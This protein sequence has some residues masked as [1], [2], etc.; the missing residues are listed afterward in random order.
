M[1]KFPSLA[2]EISQMLDYD[3]EL[4]KKSEDRLG[5]GSLSGSRLTRGQKKNFGSIRNLVLDYHNGIERFINYTLID[6]LGHRD[7]PDK[8]A[9]AVLSRL[10]FDEKVQIIR[11]FK[12]VNFSKVEFEK[13]GAINSIRN[14]FAHGYPLNNKKFLYKKKD[15]KHIVFNKDTM[16]E[17]EADVVSILDKLLSVT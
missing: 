15:S 4:A 16:R 11:K 9:E 14:A 13:I 2:E 10:G 7:R 1:S 12:I 17:F 5:F 3:E 8:F 6:Y